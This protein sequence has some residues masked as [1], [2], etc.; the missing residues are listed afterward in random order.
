MNIRVNCVSMRIRK[1]SQ[2]AFFSSSPQKN[3]YLE[4]YRS[5]FV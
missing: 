2:K 4:K 3:G 5:L 1:D